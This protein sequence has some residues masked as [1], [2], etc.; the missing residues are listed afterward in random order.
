MKTK[1]GF[2]LIETLVAV[3]ISTTFIS[4]FIK[5]NIDS[6]KQKNTTILFKEAMSIVRAVDHRIAIDGYD[7][8][9]WLNTSWDNKDDIV[10]SL[11]KKDLTSSS[12]S[13]CSDGGWSP[14]ITT[15]QNTTLLEC[16]LWENKNL[17]DY[18][19]SANLN[20]DSAGY[21]Q[22]FNLTMSF[23]S[24]DVFENNF[25]NIKYALSKVESTDYQ[26][27]AGIHTYNFKS[28]TTGSYITT[29]ECINDPINC[30]IELSFERSGGN[31]YIRADGQNSIIGST[32]TYIEAKGQSPLK[33]ARWSKDTGVWGLTSDENC[34]IGIYNNTTPALVEVAV[35]GGTYNYVV[36]DQTCTVY[37]WNGTNVVDSGATSPCGMT[38]DGGEVYQVVDNNIA[39]TSILNEVF[40]EDANINDLSATNFYVEIAS[41]ENLTT[42][43]LNSDVTNISTELN[44]DGLSTFNNEVGFNEKVDFNEV[45]NLS[46]IVSRNASCSYDGALSVLSDGELVSCI[47]GT[48]QTSAQTIMPVGS[49]VLR[50]DNINPS[51]IY[52]G[53][54]QLITGDASLSFGNGTNQSGSSYG[55][56]T[57]SVP[58]PYHRHNMAHTHTRGSM[59]ITGWFTGDDRL[60]Q[61]SN[62]GAFYDYNSNLGGN[63]ASGGG[64]TG[65]VYFSANRSWSGSTSQ[66]SSSNTGY[67]GSSGN[68]MDVRG[69]RIDI[70]VWK[71]IS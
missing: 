27:L 38:Q 31:E 15:E 20:T 51:T 68:T 3:M 5:F 37:Q 46:N 56:N 4:G 60:V 32:L 64:G 57:K 13:N 44:V 47:S 11:I 48:W 71:R 34:G 58:V 10:N 41:I 9:S 26:E 66:P 63:G 7:P 39:N 18:E 65:T 67:A 35:D 17:N 45:V 53:T 21:I 28:K 49:V 1:K 16:N 61:N 30:Q 52:G 42:G 40:A 55:D 6:N 69:A 36:L 8:S 22:S 25:K 14:S 29:Y 70:N 24:L 33:C 50:M 12:L 59:N 2:T 62:G 43:I 54:W 19:I 23:S